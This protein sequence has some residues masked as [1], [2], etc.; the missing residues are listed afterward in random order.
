MRHPLLQPVIRL[1]ALL[2]ILGCVL[3]LVA[4]HPHRVDLTPDRRFTLSPHTHEVLERL[5]DD[6]Q[7]TAFYSSQEPNA[8]REMSD[9][10][11]LY[12]DASPRVA[13]R[14]LDLD[15]SPGAA[16]RLDVGAYNSAVVEAG[17]RRER[18]ERLDE[19][20]LTAALLRVAGI[21]PTP[22][23][24]VL[25]HGEHDPRDDEGRA[26]IGVAAQ[27]MR[28]DGFVPRVVEGAGALP[29]D[30]GLV[31][32]AGPRRD[33]AEGEISALA[34]F[35]R[36]GGRLLVL[37]DHDAP[38]SVGTLLAR[39]GIEPSHDVVV[40]AR[41]KLFGTDGL[42]ARVAYLNQQ[43]IPRAPDVPALLPLAQSLRLVEVPGA[44][45]DYLAMTGDDAWADVDRRVLSTPE[46]SFRPGT[47]RRGP[48]PLAALVRV[49]SNPEA[50]GQL[51]VVGDSDF[52]TN[53]HI[54]VVGNRDLFLALAELAA[55]ND[56]LAA[57]RAPAPPGG[58]FSPLALST[59]EGR[60]L[61][62]AGVAGPGVLLFGI[63]GLV[64]HRRR[65]GHP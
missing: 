5:H 51:L 36:R 65:M 42:S 29:E 20:S 53:L 27:A 43:L 11:G 21:P 63:A 17:A 15:R 57:T 8:R 45:G 16:E 35:L 24:F 44:R 56:P 26:G 7:V 33:L 25:G 31:V 28:L 58:T 18:I 49:G 9:L 61:F 39:F 60:I 46:A 13:V 6:V 55:R 14:L 22:V 41:G 47:D 23:T 30:A 64:A 40:D 38:A 50:E 12:R 52:I 48:V 32:L 34:A 4:R 1:L 59:R 19:D 37:V 54:N 2:G 10:L 3:V 62:W